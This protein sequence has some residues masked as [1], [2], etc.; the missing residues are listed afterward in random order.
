M[1]KIGSAQA[2]ATPLLVAAASGQRAALHALL[3]CL[4]AGGHTRQEDSPG[5]AAAPPKKVAHQGEGGRQLGHLALARALT[6]RDASTGWSA[7]GWALARGDARA[8]AALLRASRA[9]AV[10]PLLLLQVVKT[11]AGQS[12]CGTAQGKGTDGVPIGKCVVGTLTGRGTEMPLDKGMDD[13]NGPSAKGVA[14][15]RSQPGCTVCAAPPP[16]QLPSADGSCGQAPANAWAELVASPAGVAV[17]RG[18]ARALAELQAAG[19]SLVNLDEP[20]APKGAGG[21]LL[22]SLLELAAALGCAQCV[23]ALLGEPC[24]SFPFAFFGNKSMGLASCTRC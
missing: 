21:A 5:A 3:D 16:V 11:A 20:G 7:L 23:E 4:T 12:R 9:A 14:G 18:G 2:G 10:P 6:A 24:S 8:V 22:S 15:R 13:L 17:L 1:T 19:V